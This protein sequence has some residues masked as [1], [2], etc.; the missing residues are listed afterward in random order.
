MDQA[1]RRFRD[2]N[3]LVPIDRDKIAKIDATVGLDHRI[4][5]VT[6]AIDRELALR[7]KPKKSKI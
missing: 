3:A 6:T 7:L 5:F 2:K 4:D 1:Q